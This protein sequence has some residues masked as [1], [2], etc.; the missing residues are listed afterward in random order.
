MDIEADFAMRDL[1]SGELAF[2]G[3]AMAKRKGQLQ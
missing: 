3:R 2:L 1:S